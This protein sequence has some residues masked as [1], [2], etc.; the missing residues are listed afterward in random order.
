MA[1]FA[2]T[3]RYL[4]AY[5]DSWANQ[6]YLCFDLLMVLTSFTSLDWMDTLQVLR[7]TLWWKKDILLMS[8]HLGYYSKIHTRYLLNNTNLFLTTWRL[9]NPWLRARRGGVWWGLVFCFTTFLSYAQVVEEE[10]GSPPPPKDTDF[11]SPNHPVT[12]QLG[13]LGKNSRI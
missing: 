3:A 11:M 7:A 5:A 12:S 1:S 10:R 6:N 2:Q 13:L 9:E 4:V 8:V